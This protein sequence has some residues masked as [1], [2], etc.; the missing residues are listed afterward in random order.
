[1]EKTKDENESELV[2]RIERLQK[3]IKPCNIG[4]AGKWNKLRK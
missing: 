1:M 2:T 4:W 3:E